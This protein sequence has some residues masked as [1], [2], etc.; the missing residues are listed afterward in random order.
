MQR[1]KGSKPDYWDYATLLELAVLDGDQQAS[2]KCLGDALT[3]VRESWE[4][5]TT[6][7]N[8]KLIREARRERGAAEPWLDAVIDSLAAAKPR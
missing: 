3:R 4:P 6:A 5:E 7:N 8:L 2:R 1:L